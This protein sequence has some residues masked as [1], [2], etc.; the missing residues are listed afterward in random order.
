MG[1]AVVVVVVAAAVVDDTAAA[2]LLL[3]A[4][5][6]TC[7]RYRRQP[8]FGTSK[9]IRLCCFRQYVF[10]FRKLSCTT[11]TRLKAAR[12]WSNLVPAGFVPQCICESAWCTGKW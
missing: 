12:H 2:P 9:T 1:V 8:V 5:R 7:N 6:T 10:R 11:S 3:H 4:C